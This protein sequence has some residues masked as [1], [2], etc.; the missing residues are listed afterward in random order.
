MRNDYIG[1]ICTLYVDANLIRRGRNCLQESR[2]SPHPELRNSL[3]IIPV[4]AIPTPNSLSFIIE[5]EQS[6]SVSYNLTWMWLSR[7]FVVNFTIIHYYYILP[8][9]PKKPLKLRIWI[10]L[11]EIIKKYT[12]VHSDCFKNGDVAR[13]ALSSRLWEIRVWVKYIS[14]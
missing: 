12:G 3:Y 14:F 9:F 10:L 5:V 4:Y 13:T 2:D 1:W 8:I 11:V 6:C 7:P